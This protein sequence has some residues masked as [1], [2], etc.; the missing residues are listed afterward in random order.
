MC[1]TLRRKFQVDGH[2]GFFDGH[3][4]YAHLLEYL[5]TDALDP[6]RQMQAEAF[7]DT[8]LRALTQHPLGDG[9]TVG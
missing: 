1:E 2:D 5:R 7:Y 8:A 9:A 6:S 3:Y 4:A